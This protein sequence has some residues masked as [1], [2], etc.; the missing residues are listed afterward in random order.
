MIYVDAVSL[1][2]RQYRGEGGVT[3]GP[4]LKQVMLINSQGGGYTSGTG[5]SIGLDIKHVHE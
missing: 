4:S 2:D 5:Y 1:F 3:L